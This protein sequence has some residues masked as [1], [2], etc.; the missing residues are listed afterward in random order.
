MTETKNKEEVD[1]STSGDLTEDRTVRGLVTEA[2]Q[3]KANRH[4]RPLGH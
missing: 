2:M 4:R 1:G 3:T